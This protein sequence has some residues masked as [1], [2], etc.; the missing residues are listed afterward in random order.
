MELEKPQHMPLLEDSIALSKVLIK[1]F[2]AVTESEL[3]VEIA[4]CDCFG[5]AGGT[6][7]RQWCR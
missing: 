3:A 7:S 5:D 6:F 2:D 1:R 4:V